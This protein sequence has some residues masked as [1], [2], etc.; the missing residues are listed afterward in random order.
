MKNKP[1]IYLDIDDVILHWQESYAK[2]FNCKILKSWTS[3]NIMKK[4]L[5]ILS[6]E[7]DFWITLPLK[8]QP[9]FQPKGFISARG[10][11]KKWTYESLKRH[12]VP[13]RS[14]IHQVNWGQSKIEKL[15]DLKVDIFIDDNPNTF[16]ECHENG[17]FCI[18][19]TMPYNVNIKTKYRIDNL[20]IENILKLWDDKNTSGKYSIAKD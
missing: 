16:K 8:N 13:G 12:N 11:P 20:N 4:R 6:E 18:L 3:S 19:M 2:R 10:I 1:S 15:K 9:N 17:I 7:K 14:N 5:S